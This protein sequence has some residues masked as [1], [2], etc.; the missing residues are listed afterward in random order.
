MTEEKNANN[1]Q[2]IQLNWLDNTILKILYLCL[3]L[4]KKKFFQTTNSF[5]FSFKVVGSAL[6]FYTDTKLSWG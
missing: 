2:L 1:F 4:D 5:V 3:L 6:A